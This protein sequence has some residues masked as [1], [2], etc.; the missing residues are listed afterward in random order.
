[1]LIKAVPTYPMN[2]FLLPTHLCTEIDDVLAKFWWGN[3]NKERGIHWLNWDNMGCAKA[4]GRMGFRN[5]MDFN[6][7]LF[8]K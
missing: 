4:D 1:M 2:V 8:A 7:A 5:L 3:R 6:T